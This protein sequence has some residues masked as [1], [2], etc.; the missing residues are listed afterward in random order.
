MPSTATITAKIGP[1]LTATAQVI[2]NVSSFTIDTDKE[3]LTVVSGSVTT[4]Y[5]IAAATT[6]LCTVSG[7][8]YTLTI[9]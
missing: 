2:N 8:N 6:I 7:N 9:S 3:L 5:D 1:G 4:Q